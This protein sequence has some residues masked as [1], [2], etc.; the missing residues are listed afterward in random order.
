MTTS[1]TLYVDC[2]HDTWKG[3]SYIRF[4]LCSN[5]FL[6]WFCFVTWLFSDIV[7]RKWF[8][9]RFYA[10]DVI[11]EKSYCPIMIMGPTWGPP[12]SCRPQISP[13]LALRT[14]L[15]GVSQTAPTC[16]LGAK[17]SF[18]P[19]VS[20]HRKRHMMRHK[21]TMKKKCSHSMKLSWMQSS[22]AFTRYV[23]K[24][25][26]SLCEHHT[27]LNRFWGLSWYNV[28]LSNYSIPIIR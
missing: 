19:M 27:S 1:S 9:N 14:L 2:L 21:H 23:R 15:S 17:P 12:G 20:G 7:I 25:P 8:N 16:L 3:W 28:L 24:H 10:I 6:F 5:I 11:M 26:V 13:M 18:N 22:A 4:K